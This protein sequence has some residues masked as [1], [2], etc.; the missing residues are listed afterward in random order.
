MKKIINYIPDGSKFLVDWL[1]VSFREDSGLTPGDILDELCLILDCDKEKFVYNERGLLAGYNRSFRYLDEK[2]IAISFNEGNSKQ[3]IL[4]NVTGQGCKFLSKEN[5]FD[6]FKFSLEK[7]GYFTRLDIAFDD[8]DQKLPLHLIRN[9]AEAV[10]VYYRDDSLDFM[11]S[12][13]AFKES[14]KTFTNSFKS[15]FNNCPN[16]SIGTRYGLCMVRYYNK[17][18]EQKLKDMYWWRCE[19]QLKMEYAEKMVRHLLD[20]NFVPYFVQLLLSHSR[21]LDGKRLS[22]VTEISTHPDF[23]KFLQYLLE[24]YEVDNSLNL[25]LR[26][27]SNQNYP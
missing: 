8:I 9:V 18:V 26:N 3:G 14:F 15:S 19:L 20:G 6:I 7:G 17:A 2:L 24:E 11:I 10:N 16:L 1:S 5:L 21:F 12:S 27:Y 25:Y 22:T 13:K 23:E 4:L